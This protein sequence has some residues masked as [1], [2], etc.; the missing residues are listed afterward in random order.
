M[1]GFVA[2]WP[3]HLSYA[4]IVGDVVTERVQTALGKAADFSEGPQPADFATKPEKD[5][6]ARW[7]SDSFSWHDWDGFCAVHGIKPDSSY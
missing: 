2:A 1:E 4:M 3:S 5:Q 6:V 7:E